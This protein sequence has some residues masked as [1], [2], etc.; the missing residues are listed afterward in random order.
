M[1]SGDSLQLSTH[2]FTVNGAFKIDV[3]GQSH[4]IIQ[5]AEF[6]FYIFKYIMGFIGTV[7]IIS[8]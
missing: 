8:Q 3:L 5:N 2:Y 4:Y 1:T 7:S 6:V